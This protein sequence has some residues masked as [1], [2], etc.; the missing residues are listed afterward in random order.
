[1]RPHELAELVPPSTVLKR[2]ARGHDVVR[3]QAWLTLHGHGVLLDGVFGPATE[4]AL[5]DW[6]REQEAAAHG[7]GPWRH[8]EVNEQTWAELTAPMARAIGLTQT[9]MATGDAIV[10]AARQHLYN[11][12]REVGGANLG[13]WVRLYMDGNQGSAWPWCA[14]FATYVVRQAMG[15]A[16]ERW[17]T[18]SCDELARRAMAWGC[19]KMAGGAVENVRPGDLF[20]IRG[21]SLHVQDW[22]HCGIVTHVQAECFHTIEGNT[23]ESGG[24]EGYEVAARIRA[25]NTLTDFVLLGHS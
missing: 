5:I 9:G 14:G 8:G 25:F 17:R 1:M 19:F 18:F 4:A 3:L 24:S 6:Q 13:P 20:L 15:E 2:G 10:L 7:P 23:N 11:G 16:G 21:P 22:R 12:P